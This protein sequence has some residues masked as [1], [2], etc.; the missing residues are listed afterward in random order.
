MNAVVRAR[1][2]E[3]VKAEA[4]AVL[5]QIGLTPSSAFRLLMVRTAAEKRLPFE[6]LQ[7]NADTLTAI[8]EARTQGGTERF[9]TAAALMA[10]LHADD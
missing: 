3:D 8:K 10:D 7:P 6:L 1:I 4:E 9:A 5:S 2:E